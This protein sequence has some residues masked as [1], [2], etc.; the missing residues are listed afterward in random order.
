VIR[1][2]YVFWSAKN[3]ETRLSFPYGLHACEAVTLS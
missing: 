1:K 3:V 2:T